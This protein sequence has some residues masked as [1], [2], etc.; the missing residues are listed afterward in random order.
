M[1]KRKEKNSYNRKYYYDRETRL[2]SSKQYY[3]RNK[4]R[5]K[6]YAIKYYLKNEKTI[7]KNQKRWR[8]D[9]VEQIKKYQ[10]GWRKNNVDKRLNYNLNRKF[11]INLIDYNNLMVKQNNVC[12]VCQN[13]EVAKDHRTGLTRKLS[14]DHNHKTKKIRGLLCNNCNTALGKI[15]DDPKLLMKMIN[16]LDGV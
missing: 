2:K 15:K 13:P 4:E 16:Y 6:V 7:K 5:R 9:N 14:V 3:H 11:N 12:A 8:G 10:S 1:Q